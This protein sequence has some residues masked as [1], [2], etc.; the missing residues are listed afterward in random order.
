MPIQLT[1]PKVTG[2]FDTEAVNGQYA[3]VKIIEQRL[4]TKGEFIELLLEY[5]NT[6]T[7][8]WVSGKMNPVKVQIVNSMGG[9]TDYNDIIASLPLDGNEAIYA[10]AK[11]VLYQWLIDNGHFAGTVV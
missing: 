10:G 4:N 9:G 5:G 2:D 3:E 6:D 7:G 11:R 8:A 1:A